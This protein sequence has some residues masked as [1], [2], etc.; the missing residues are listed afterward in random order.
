MRKITVYLFTVSL[1]STRLL[2]ADLSGPISKLKQDPSNE[3][4]KAEITSI[5]KNEPSLI[6]AALVELDS[7]GQPAYRCSLGEAISRTG[8]DRAQRKIA[9]LLSGAD[10]DLAIC[11]SR[12]AG[13]S[14]NP[15]AMA[16]LSGNI[17]DFVYNSD[18]SGERD[19]KKKIAAINSIWA[20]GEIGSE[21]VMDKLE[22]YYNGSD[23]TLRINIIF[24]MGKLKDARV[25][26][27]LSKIAG[28]EKESEAVR[29][30]AYEMIDELG[31]K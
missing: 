21:K 4:I 25:L 26:P 10:S 15:Y 24:S 28:N 23:E 17:E 29:S 3:T 7:A 16:A 31:G 5:L 19:V 22:K 8:S 27:Y 20:L 13:E 30:A 18:R 1:F 9:G 6:D 11:L 2:A 14:K 12:I